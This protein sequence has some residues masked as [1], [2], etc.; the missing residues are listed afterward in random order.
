MYA[1]HFYRFLPRDYP[2]RAALQHLRAAVALPDSTGEEGRGLRRQAAT[3]GIEPR[4]MFMPQKN[5]LADGPLKDALA[6]PADA[7]SIDRA[8]LEAALVD[9]KLPHLADRLDESAPWS[10]RLSPGEQQR[11]AFAR[12]L[13]Y[14]PDIRWL[15][16][17][18]NCTC[19]CTDV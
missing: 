2:C 3:T 14:R 5:Y 9:C 11:L 17:R 4:I 6:Y 1:I 12:A 19:K 18:T 13:L 8:A 16:R 7:D 15:G 10:H